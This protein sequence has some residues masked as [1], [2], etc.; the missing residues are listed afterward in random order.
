L[1]YNPGMSVSFDASNVF[2]NRNGYEVISSQID[3]RPDEF[4]CIQRQSSATYLIGC[5]P[6]SAIMDDQEKVFSFTFK[7]IDRF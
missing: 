2:L 7:I 5:L 3:S 6:S 1:P 4:H